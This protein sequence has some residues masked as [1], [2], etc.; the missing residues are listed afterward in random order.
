MSKIEKQN[1]KQKA[2]PF[3][4][5]YLEGQINFIEEISEEETQAVVGGGTHMTPKSPSYMTT[6][7]YPS[8]N[9]D[10]SGGCKIGVTE[11]YPSDSDNISSSDLIKDVT[12]KFPSDSDECFLK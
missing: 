1:L 4:A 7:K 3:F 10:I 8:D 2:V 9:E 6:M 11:K 12:A 5:R